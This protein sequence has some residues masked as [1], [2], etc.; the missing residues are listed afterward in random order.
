M[1][2]AFPSR[3]VSLTLIF[4]FFTFTTVGLPAVEKQQNKVAGRI[5]DANHDKGVPDA[6]VRVTEMSSGGSYDTKTDKNGCYEFDNLPLGN[7]SVTVTDKG[8]DYLYADKLQIMKTQNEKNLFKR[9]FGL[10]TD[11][12]LMLMSDKECKLCKKFPLLWVL[13]GTGGGIIAA[14]AAGQEEEAS[15]SNP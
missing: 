11:G 5:Y 7:Y 8:K 1:N 12:S 3:L 14:I 2:H 4:A 13:I 10:N 15:P 9:C 6:N